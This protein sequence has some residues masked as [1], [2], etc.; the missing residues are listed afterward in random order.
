MKKLLKFTMTRASIL[1]VS[2]LI[3]IFGIVSLRLNKNS[4]FMT[5]SQLLSVIPGVTGSYIRKGFYHYAMERCSLD[6]SIGFGTLF[7][8]WDTEIAD[9]VYIGPQCNI[10][11]SRIDKN[12]L[13]GS[14]VHILSGKHQHSFEDTNCPIQQQGGRYQKIII[15]EDSWIGNGAIIMS[16]IGR[17]CVVAAGSVVTKPTSDYAVVAGNPAKCVKKRNN[18]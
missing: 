8:Q 18:I 10:G 1:L 17:H 15:G 12:C 14:G 13:I 4:W 11:K 16:D 6:C 3:L 7:S 5:V 2:P 9:G